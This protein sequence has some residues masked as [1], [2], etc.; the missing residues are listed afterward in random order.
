[1]ASLGELWFGVNLKDNTSKQADEIKKRL[2][3]KLSITLNPAIKSDLRRRVLEQLKE[4]FGIS[5]S[6]EK[7]SREKLRRQI[8][9]L[10]D[11]ISTD[12]KN[13]AG[14]LRAVRAVAVME[15]HEQKLAILREQTR[16]STANA[17]AAE[18][19]LNTAR[20]NAAR[21]NDRLRAAQD[22]LNISMEKG[23]KS[24]S[25]LNSAFAKI[26]GIVALE[27]L[28]RKVVTV[29]GDFEFMEQAI[30]SL[31]GSEQQGVEL[32]GKLREFAKVSPLEVRDVTKAA[33]TLLGFNVELE[34]VPDMI[35]RLGDVSMGNKDRFNALALAFAQT[36]S[37][38]RLTGEDLRQYVNAGFNPL[39]VMAEK[40]GKSMR[41][42]KEEMSK[43]AISVEMV[44]Q[45]FIDATSAGGKFYNMSE[46]QTQ[47]I[48]G[49][50]SKL[51]DSIDRAFESL[52][53]DNQGVIKGAIASVTAL[54]DNYEQVGRVLMGLLTTY[55]TYR[56]AVMLTTI[57]Q[58]GHSLAMNIARLRILA[59]QKA[60]ALLNA[61]MLS[62]P[63][64]VAATALGVLVGALIASSDGMTAAERAQ[65]NFND[66]IA[67]GT[68]K[69]RQ[70]NAETEQ[71]ISTANSDTEATGARREALNLLIDR[72]GDIIKKYID[73][74]GHLRDILQLKREIAAI[75]G[76]RNVEDLTAK[77][78][79][80][81][82]AAEAAKLL[83]NGKPLTKNQKKLIEETK[84]EYF[85]ANGFWAKAWYNDNDLIEWAQQMSG[86]YG[87]KARREASVNAQGRFQDIITDMTDAQLKALQSTLRNAKSK[88]KNI[89]LAGYKELSNV[90]LTPDDIERLMTYTGGI[91]DSRKPQART[92]KVIE[93]ERKAA[94]TELEALTVAEAN[95]KKGAE[96]RRKI[97]GYSKELEAYDAKTKTT[98]HTASHHD[99][100]EKLTGI[101]I[102]QALAARRRTID[103]EYS[104]RQA[105]ISAMEEGT[106]KVLAQIELDHDRRL[107]AI[108]RE[109]E[110]LRQ[111]RIKEAKS[112][113]DADSTKKGTNFYNSEAYRKASSEALTEQQQH[114]RAAQIKE[115]NKEYAEALKKQ[116]ELETRA[117]FDYLSQFGSI[118][119]MRLAIKEDYDRRIARTESQWQKKQLEKERD[120]AIE[121]MSAESL[122][123][124]IDL[125]TLF[126]EYGVILASPLEETLRQLKKYTET[127]AFRARSF[128]DQ[129][130]I[131]QAIRNTESQLNGIGKISFSDIGESLYEYNNSLIAYRTASDELEEAAKEAITARQE[132]ADAEELLAKATT[133]EAREI[134]M[135]TKTQAQGKETAANT[136]Y[137]NKLAQFNAAQGRLAAAQSAASENLRKF[138]ISIDNVGNIAR[139]VASGSMKQLWESLGAKTQK[140]IGQFVSG[141]KK[142]DDAVSL[143]TS[144]LSK[145]GKGVDY[146]IERIQGVAAEIYESGEKIEASGLGDKIAKLFDELF[147]KDSSKMKALGEDVTKI[148]N[149]VLNEGKEAGASTGEVVKQAATEAVQAI[150]KSGGS[151]WVMIVGLIMDLLD[152][153]SEGIGALVETLL[154]KVGAAIE[155]ILSEIGSGK[156]FERIFKGVGNVIGGI[157]KGIGNLFSGGYAFGASNVEEME[158]EIAE[159]AQTNEALAKSIDSL[160]KAI[161]DKDSTNSESEEAYKRALAAEKEWQANQRKAIS[162]RASEW[163]SSGNGFLGLGGKH[164]FNAYL[165]GD[166]GMWDDFNKVLSQFGYENRVYSANDLWKLSPEMMQLL[167]D[168]APK[169]WAA[170]L[171]TDGKANPSELINEYIDKA[172]KIDELTSA[173]NEKLTGYTWDSFK[174]SYI[175]ILKDLD[176]TNEDFADSLE[177]KLSN[178]ILRSLI[179]ET[180]KDRIKALYQ[181]IADAASDESEGG[182]TMTGGELAAIRAA[183]ESLASELIQARE[184]LMEAGILK[185]T[186]GGSSSMSNAIKGVTE[187]TA[188]LLAS[189][190]NTI[191]A[192]ESVVR[193]LVAQYLPQIAAA[194]TGGETKSLPGISEGVEADIS[195]GLG[196][197]GLA[198]VPQIDTLLSQ[199]TP[200][201]ELIAGIQRTN[202]TIAESQ[203]S[204]LQQIAEHTKR[205][206]DNTEAMYQL[207]NDMGTVKDILRHSQDG[208][209]SLH[210]R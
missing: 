58:N 158:K 141:T 27:E 36:T 115:A 143:A 205:T 169:A 90:V 113:W 80:Y 78:R 67:E 20:A 26:G 91:V 133:D 88:K 153:L 102:E 124:E 130:S 101:Q 190:I 61:T 22:R 131:Y 186:S 106:E 172:G 7:E 120:A 51:G 87:K 50:L 134:A 6:V 95:G 162:D 54:V 28:A 35:Q 73:E 12:R 21:A 72:Y 56:T 203:V 49:Q 39:Q 42:L 154:D 144:L 200:H 118:Q 201:L 86:E 179:N 126:S 188:D 52:G 13:S 8:K 107:E 136:N 110:D 83:I 210:V 89:V 31:V 138:Q 199:I 57:A 105:E 128:E 156:F 92:K 112:L 99:T 18:V 63:Y 68:E 40:T 193:A 34:K 59:T 139:A 60:Q 187:Q 114:N 209:Q 4:P 123:K 3:K 82:D 55:G 207:A 171:S 94:Q 25:L 79:R 66:A 103:M 38:A 19:R 65:K 194:V 198:N 30:K 192:D 96:L 178:A 197:M 2:E 104:T 81:T 15:E 196:G 142:F 208:S 10:L 77:A 29:T 32:M 159:L 148:L 69:Q 45:A 108:R 176:S 202:S 111:Q 23:A 64:V 165:N 43:G 46:K 170:L 177:E 163:S 48:N 5:I 117:M 164:S 121:S 168:Y 53:R 160:A 175:D 149:K 44:E 9:P 122:L 97:A 17:D 16:K 195:N 180:Y 184:N 182:S 14:D 166:F 181:M 151:L 76:N 157:I 47:T 119:Q 146:F 140:R 150:S 41:D 161:S 116:A 167:R 74:K 191:R 33:Q 84:E 155:G 132:V 85:G 129:Q 135:K 70:Y 174:D 189:Y 127:D 1:M 100:A 173:L 93:D 62:N 145:Q 206:A 147:G 204:Q 98:S 75:D 185:K 137:N 109:F 11:G 37:A 71:A 24:R 152:V 183:N 125:S